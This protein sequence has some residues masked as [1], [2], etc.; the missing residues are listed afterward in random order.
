MAYVAPRSL[1]ESG[2]LDVDILERWAAEKDIHLIRFI[3]CCVY[4][5]TSGIIP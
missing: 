2:R 4:T 1:E 3:V 5:E